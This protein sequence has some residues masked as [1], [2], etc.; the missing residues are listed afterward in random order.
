MDTSVL[1]PLGEEP[2]QWPSTSLP[3]ASRAGPG[4]DVRAVQEL[5]QS[6]AGHRVRAVDN[7]CY[8]LPDGERWQASFRLQVFTAAG[9]RPVAIATQIP[10]GEG[11]SLTNIAET[12]AGDVWRQH[13]PDEADPPIWI[14]HQILDDHRDLTMVT[15]TADHA[16][17]TLHDPQWLHLSGADVET[18]VG[19]PVDL[20][21]GPGF[22]PVEPQPDT[23]PVY[24]A[25]A[26]VLLPRPR[27]FRQ[28]EC[29]PVGVPWWRRLG[30]QLIARRGARTCCWYHGGDWHVV[31]RVAVRLTAQ[32]RTSGVAFDE[33]VG[34]VLSQ[35]AARA[36][37]GW[38]Q[39]AL[40]SLMTDTIR[41]YSSWPRR[42]GY[43]NGQHRAQAMIDAGVRRT[44]VERR[45]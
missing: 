17:R 21:R 39:Q 41:P 5:L 40:Y 6:H 12:C 27:P 8:R 1:D 25:A 11:A 20:E 16:G 15:F 18:L 43:N 31:S 45:V 37:T 44:L 29:M 42:K 23:E 26:V 24:A 10:G 2:C 19:Q 4:A 9:L 35:P 36:L 38:E 33:T 28:P 3:C 32:A 13:F 14:A 34:Y 7:P 22:V 30:R